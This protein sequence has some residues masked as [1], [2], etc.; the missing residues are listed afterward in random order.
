MAHQVVSD[1]TKVSENANVKVFVRARPPEASDE[2]ADE[3]FE[4]GE[5][6]KGRVKKLTMKQWKRTGA[7]G[8]RSKLRW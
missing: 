5:V 1:Y 8:T 2:P 7:S 4:R 3:L 6:E